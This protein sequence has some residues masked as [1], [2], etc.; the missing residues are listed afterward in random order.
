MQNCDFDGDR[1]FSS[2]MKI[3]KKQE[4]VTIKKNFEKG[5]IT[6]KLCK[7]CGFLKNVVSAKN[8]F[9]KTIDEI[10]KTINHLQKIKEELQ[11][12]IS[13]FSKANTKAEQLTI[14][15]LTKNN[16]TMRIAFEELNKK[17]NR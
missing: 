5:I 7:T 8:H 3:L 6:C 9:D 13:Q 16:P 11:G 12:T 4:T 1:C 10:D 17:E 14:R 2:N 15:S